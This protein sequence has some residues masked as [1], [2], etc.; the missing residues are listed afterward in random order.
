MVG[1]HSAIVVI[2]MATHAGVRRVIVISIVACGTLHGNGGMSSPQLIKIVVIRQLCRHPPR[3]GGVALGTISSKI[4]VLVVRV[5]RTVE[6][7][8][9]AVHA[10]R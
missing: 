6:V 7:I 9:V 3:L 1:V 8:L 2:L 4:K 5:H 10:I